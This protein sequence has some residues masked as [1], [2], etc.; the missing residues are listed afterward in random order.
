MN[1][2]L[3]EG[4][5]LALQIFFTNMRLAGK[6]QEEI[7]GLF[8]EEYLKFSGNNPDALEDTSGN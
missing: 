8:S 5:K 6:T 1:E 4:A 7:D 3:V 2:I